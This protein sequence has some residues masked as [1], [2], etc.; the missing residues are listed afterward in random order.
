MFQVPGLPD[1]DLQTAKESQSGS[2][3]IKRHFDTLTE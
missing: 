1:V 2:Y 3:K